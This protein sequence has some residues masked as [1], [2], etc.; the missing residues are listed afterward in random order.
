MCLNGIEIHCLLSRRYRLPLGAILSLDIIEVAISI[1]SVIVEMFYYHFGAISQSIVEE[2]H[3]SK[4]FSAQRWI[5]VI[6][7]FVI[8]FPLFHTISEVN[9]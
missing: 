9:N 4:L 6:L 1:G 5:A 7:A 8:S 2:L 3:F